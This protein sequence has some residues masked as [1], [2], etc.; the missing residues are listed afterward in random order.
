MRLLHERIT[1]REKLTLEHSWAP[2]I[3]LVVVVTFCFAAWFLAP[4]GEN[5]TYVP[6]QLTS[7][8]LWSGLLST[9]PNP[10]PFMARRRSLHSRF[11]HIWHTRRP[12]ESLPG[13]KLYS[14]RVRYIRG[15]CCDQEPRWTRRLFGTPHLDAMSVATPKYNSLTQL[16]IVSGAPLLSSLQRPCTSC[17]R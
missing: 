12:W 11:L 4:K 9:D 3:G 6:P 1:P 2:F 14:E 17:G 15:G 8:T 13:S 16:K 7:C 10:T 5:Q